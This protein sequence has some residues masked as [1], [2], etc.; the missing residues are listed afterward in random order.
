MLELGGF[1][2]ELF[3]I[4]PEGVFTYVERAKTER[5]NDS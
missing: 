5:E 2:A 3:V 1:G 4:P